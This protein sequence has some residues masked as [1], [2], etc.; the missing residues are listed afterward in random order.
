MYCIVMPVIG[1]LLHLL[2]A[3]CRSWTFDATGAPSRYLGSVKLEAY[4]TEY[5]PASDFSTVHRMYTGINLTLADINWSCECN[6]SA[7]TL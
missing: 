2:F 6:N 5:L 7:F 3:E 1:K 4:T